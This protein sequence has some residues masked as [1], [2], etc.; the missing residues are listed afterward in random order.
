[1]RKTP[2]ETGSVQ[3]VSVRENRRRRRAV[4]LEG[5]ERI[6]RLILTVPV[7]RKVMGG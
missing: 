7:V 3:C 5:W 6:E 4:E 1:M 2:T